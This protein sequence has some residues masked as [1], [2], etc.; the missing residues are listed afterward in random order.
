M[1]V[2]AITD[3]IPQAKDKFAEIIVHKNVNYSLGFAEKTPEERRAA[4][5]DLAVT[6][7]ANNKAQNLLA[8]A[9]AGGLSHQPFDALR[10]HLGLQDQNDDLSLSIQEKYSITQIRIADLLYLALNGNEHAF[11]LLLTAPDASSESKSILRFNLE[12]N[13]MF[14]LLAANADLAA[15]ETSVTALLGNHMNQVR[16]LT[17]PNDIAEG[18]I[19]FFTKMGEFVFSGEERINGN[20]EKK[21]EEQAKIEG[22]LQ[23]NQEVITRASETAARIQAEIDAGITY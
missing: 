11:N 9:N 23:Q 16:I 4:L 6:N 8:K 7:G 2:T 14:G 15:L 3:L 20:T 21:A 13:H 18:Q 19:D 1:E 5:T 17:R 12:M 22:I 10:I